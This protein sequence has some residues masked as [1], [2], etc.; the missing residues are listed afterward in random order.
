MDGRAD[1]AELIVI[2]SGTGGQKILTLIKRSAIYENDNNNRSKHRDNLN[3][4]K[5]GNIK[6]NS[7]N[8]N[9]NNNNYV[10][11]PS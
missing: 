1:T 11:E 10:L 2:F 8:N 3:N 5:N 7:N 4:R 9:E 6:S